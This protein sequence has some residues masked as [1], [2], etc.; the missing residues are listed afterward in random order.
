MHTRINPPR[1]SWAPALTPAASAHLDLVRGFAAWAVMWGHLRA[2]FFV[3][4]P[5]VQH[6]VLP[7][8]ILYFFTGFGNEAVLVFFVLSGFLISSAIL[9]RHA[10]GSW[11][12]RDYAV[13]RL[14]RLY[15]VLIP[16]LALGFLWDKLGSALF[17]STGLYSHPLDSFGSTVVQN[18]LGIEVLL[19]NLSFLQTILCPTFGSNGPLWSLANE[20]WYYVMFPLALA[21]ASAWKRMSF[22]RAIPLTVLLACVAVFVRWKILLGFPIWLAGTA[23][24]V[25]YSKRTVPQGRFRLVYLSLSSILLSVCLIAARTGKSALL[26]SD[27][28]VGIAFALFLLGVLRADFDVQRRFYSRIAHGL[29]GF[30]YSLYVLHFPFLLFLRAWIA[31]YQ[32]WQPDTLHL[33]SGVAIG[34]LVLGFAWFVSKATEEKTGVVRQWMK[35]AIPLLDA[36][37][38]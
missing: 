13:D 15:V 38:K 11:S 7:L 6:R 24:V 9:T 14:S 22:H 35:Q 23:L 18:Q 12:W 4:Y 19:G 17:A 10:C 3:D 33:A 34:V 1:H 2:L 28:S 32:K 30:S 5:Q 37:S 36:Q 26:G 16:G 25:A 20:F 29:A 8:G 21:G 27:L 31:P